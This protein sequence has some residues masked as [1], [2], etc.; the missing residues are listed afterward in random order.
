MSVP[1]LRRS[2][3]QTAQILQPLGVP[4]GRTPAQAPVPRVQTDTL[5][6]VGKDFCQSILRY[7]AVAQLLSL[8]HSQEEDSLCLDLSFAAVVWISL[9]GTIN[10]E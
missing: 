4:E 6:S 7:F 1:K 9:V 5:A 10:A 8:S 3:G 2:H